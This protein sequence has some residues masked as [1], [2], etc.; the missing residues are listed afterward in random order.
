MRIAGVSRGEGGSLLRIGE[1]VDESFALFG[2]GVGDLFDG[3]VEQE[4]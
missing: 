4:G 3:V 2:E 1:P